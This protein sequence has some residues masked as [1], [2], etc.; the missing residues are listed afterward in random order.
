M[1]GR[2]YDTRAGAHVTALQAMV[3][4][5]VLVDIQKYIATAARAAFCFPFRHLSTPFSQ[6]L[7]SFDSHRAVNLC[8]GSKY[9]AC[10]LKKLGRKEH[11]KEVF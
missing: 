3:E 2:A 7:A 11:T 1:A 4:P 10:A 8:I 5:A 6:S 9:N